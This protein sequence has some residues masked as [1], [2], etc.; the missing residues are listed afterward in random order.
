MHYYF[1]MTERKGK[2]ICP[3]C[4]RE[5]VKNIKWKCNLCPN[6]DRH[7]IIWIV[8]QRGIIHIPIIESS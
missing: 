7:L 1:Y 4:K 3:I 2:K 5:L 6:C 8:D